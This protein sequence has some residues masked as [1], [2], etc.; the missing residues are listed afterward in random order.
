MGSITTLKIIQFLVAVFANI[1]ALS[2]LP[3]TA[4]FSKPGPTIGCIA[5]FV[6]NLFML[7][8]LVHTGTGLSILIPLMTGLIPLSMIAVGIFFYGETSSLLRV[9][10]LVAA[11]FLAA[12]AA[13]QH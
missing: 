5:L 10:L 13:T 2:L 1:G 7:A 12:A 8:R 11:C 3:M 9:S 6:L 4:G